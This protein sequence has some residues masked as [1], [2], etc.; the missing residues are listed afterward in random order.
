[1]E[2]RHNRIETTLSHDPESGSGSL[3]LRREGARVDKMSHVEVGGG[4][5]LTDTFT[6][7]RGRVRDRVL[8]YPHRDMNMVSCD[9]GP[10]FC[11]KEVHDHFE[12]RVLGY[13]FFAAVVRVLGQ[14]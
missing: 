6:H 8:T 3:R 11:G 13:F 14:S 4:E 2:S 10:Q 12:G 7:N 9:F 5:D 1:M